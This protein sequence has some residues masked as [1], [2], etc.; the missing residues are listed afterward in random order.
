VY[1]YDGVTYRFNSASHAVGVFAL[2]NESGCQSKVR[3]IKVYGNEGYR[4]GCDALISYAYNVYAN[5]GTCAGTDRNANAGGGLP[6]YTLDTH[7]PGP[8]DYALSGAASPA[9][10][11]VPASMGCPATDARGN[12]RGQNGFCDAGAY[13][14]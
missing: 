14:R 2:F 7:S 4:N 12:P 13:E 9:D 8:L 11:L 10:N 3:N 6:F 5:S 1:G